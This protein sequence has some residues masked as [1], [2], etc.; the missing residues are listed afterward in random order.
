MTWMFEKAASAKTKEFLTRYGCLTDESAPRGVATC[1]AEASSEASPM[2]SRSN[3]NPLE[4][5][6][7]CNVCNTP[8]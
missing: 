2:R 7:R 8:T 6:D 5:R 4:L 3:S 1:S